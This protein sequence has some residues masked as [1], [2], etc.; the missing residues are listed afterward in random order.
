V[1]TGLSA[2]DSTIHTTRAWL[3]E[4]I[5]L[6][7]RPDDPHRAYLALRAVLHALRDRL[8]VD[9]AASL[10]AQL[11]MLV[12]GF[13]YE[14][15]HPHGKPLKERHKE[16]FLAHIRADFRQDPGLD[17]EQVARAVFQFLA[18]HVTAGEVEKLK[19][20]LPGEIRS[21]WPEEVHALS[22]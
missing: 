8:S 18:R 19:H 22:L 10:A 15:W 13:Y 5:G 7:G 6:L 3:N 1:G 9:E 2:F 4:L 16:E 12:R 17:P 21:L 11:P 14:G 20:T